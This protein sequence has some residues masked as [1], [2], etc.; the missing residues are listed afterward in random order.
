MDGYTIF[1]ISS[2]AMELLLE[3]HEGVCLHLGWVPVE[4][5][6]HIIQISCNKK[7][8]NT[9]KKYILYF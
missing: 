7:S 2:P 6:T 4:K 1:K 9:Q 5:N 8:E 3:V